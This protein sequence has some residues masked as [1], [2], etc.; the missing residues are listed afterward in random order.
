MQIS[1]TELKR[2][3]RN[4][5]EKERSCHIAHQIHD[6]KCLLRS[7]GISTSASESKSSILEKAAKYIEFLQ[8]RQCEAEIDRQQIFKQMLDIRAA[9]GNGIFGIQQAHA[10]PSENMSYLSFHT[11]DGIR[12]NDI[13]RGT[14]NVLEVTRSEGLQFRL[15]IQACSAGI[16]SEQTFKYHD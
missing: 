4:A 5:R 15:I 3:E 12:Q 11:N 9:T 1:G 6:L 10:S 2:K 16:V 14:E 8:N 7:G 13:P